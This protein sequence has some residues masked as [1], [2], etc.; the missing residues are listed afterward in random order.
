M[1]KPTEIKALSDKLNFDILATKHCLKDVF[2]RD[3]AVIDNRVITKKDVLEFLIICSSC[4]NKRERDELFY[5]NLM[6]KISR[7]DPKMSIPYFIKDYFFSVLLTYLDRTQN[8]KF[9]SKIGY[10]GFDQENTF[11]IT[12]LAEVDHFYVN[13]VYINEKKSE[14]IGAL[15]AQIVD[16]MDF[17]KEDLRE[18]LKRDYIVRLSS[19]LV[20]I[21]G[22]RLFIVDWIR[23]IFCEWEDIGRNKKGLDKTSHG[24]M[25]FRKEKKIDY[26]YYFCMCETL[27]KSGYKP[28]EVYNKLAKLEFRS[29][30]SIRRRY[31]DIKRQMKSR[32]INYKSLIKQHSLEYRIFESERRIKS[33]LGVIS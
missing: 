24:L 2:S 14:I 1:L 3:S 31:Y 29:A 11:Y 12:M 27:K 4:I 7:I 23:D 9:N 13:Y 28:E 21:V 25:S 8:I 15:L 5:N 20:Q 30:N 33:E 17:G 26:I 32:G 10:L 19:E 22:Y 16:R 6:S 18:N